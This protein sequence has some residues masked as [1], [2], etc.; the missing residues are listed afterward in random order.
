VNNTEQLAFLMARMKPEDGV[1]LR[2]TLL[3]LAHLESFMERVANTL[4]CVPSRKDSRPDGGNAHVIT[5]LNGIVAELEM[6]R[7][8]DIVCDPIPTPP[9]PAD[10]PCG[11]SWGDYPCGLHK[12]HEGPCVCGKNSSYGPCGQ[13]FAARPAQSAETPTPRTDAHSGDSVAKSC[14]GCELDGGWGPCHCSRWKYKDN[15]RAKEV[16]K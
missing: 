11:N 2:E 10:T 16:A 12:G 15:Y 5:K 9:P 4:D 6:W 1:L 8:G 13:T 7:S 14:E 3:H